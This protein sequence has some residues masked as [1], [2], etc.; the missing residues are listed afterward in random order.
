MGAFYM[1]KLINRWGLENFKDKYKRLVSLYNDA[2]LS[3]K[4]KISFTLKT[5]RRNLFFKEN[6]PAFTSDKLDSDYFYF[7]DGK[8][9][10]HVIERVSKENWESRKKN[11]YCPRLSDDELYCLVHD[12]YRDMTDEETFKTF[13]YMFKRRDKWLHTTRLMEVN[14]DPWSLFLPYFNE[15]HIRCRRDR[16]S[17]NDP[18]NLAHEYGH[19]VQFLTNF[20]PNIFSGNEFYVEIVS[21]FF[22]LLMFE[23]LSGIPEFCPAAEYGRARIL[24]NNIKVSEEVNS[25]GKILELWG[26]VFSLPFSHGKKILNNEVR[27]LYGNEC[28]IKSLVEKDLVKD[29]PYIVGY[30]FAIEILMNYKK[31]R[32]WGLAILRGLLEIDLSRPCTE[33]Y[34]ELLKLGITP[35]EHLEEYKQHILLPKGKN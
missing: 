1:E 22:E 4:E 30:A 31:D 12:F 19:G 7:L 3:D 27:A 2:S 29:I 6:N 26:F 9:F 15:V 20:H 17:L 18:V 13:M 28:S 34:Q 23:Y 25:Y 11:V 5:M 33:Y 14:P 21:I 32:E 35:G 10:A 24:H 16:L 8:D